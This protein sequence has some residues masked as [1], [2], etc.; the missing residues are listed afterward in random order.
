MPIALSPYHPVTLRKHLPAYLMCAPTM[1]LFVVFMIFPIAFVFYSSLFN[2][3]GFGSIREAQWIGLENYRRLVADAYWWMAVRNTLLYALLK[4]L[5]ELPLAL[6][7][8]LVLNSG[9]R[10][11]TFFRTA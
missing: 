10:G 7:V 4:L 9:L 5:V 1:L 11:K 3:D 8:A 2:W 6:V